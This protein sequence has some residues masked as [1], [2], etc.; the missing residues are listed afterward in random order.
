MLCDSA[1]QDLHDHFAQRSIVRDALARHASTAGHRPGYIDQAVSSACVKD[2]MLDRRGL[3]IER[4]LVDRAQAFRDLERKSRNAWKD[5]CVAPDDPDED[6]DNDNERDDP[7]EMEDAQARRELAYNDT[8]QR[9][10]WRLSPDRATAIQQQAA[11]WRGG[12]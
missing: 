7:D 4:A 3:S 9:Q 11:A 8:V 2:T 10:Q 12:K 1:Q 6:D 5:A